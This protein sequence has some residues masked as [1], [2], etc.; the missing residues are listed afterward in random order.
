VFDDLVIPIWPF[1]LALALILG[2]ILLGMIGRLFGPKSRVGYQLTPLMTPA[3]RSFYGVLVQ[4]T[5]EDWRAFAKVRMADVLTPEKGLSRSSWQGAFN[6]ISAKHFDFLLCD[7]GDCSPKLGL[8]LDD[9]SHQRKR[10]R[11]RDQLVDTACQSAGLPL[12]RVK[13]ARA[14][15]IADLRKQI[16]DALTPPEA[17]E[18]AARATR[19]TNERREPHF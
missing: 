1:A 9:K 15:V 10:R 14:Y 3:E 8:E 2:I 11:Q 7:P 6:A 17:E 16:E 5:G 12:L 19:H 18:A 4:A 13:A